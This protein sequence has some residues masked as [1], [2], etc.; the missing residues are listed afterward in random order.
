MKKLLNK[1]QTLSFANKLIDLGIDAVEALRFVEAVDRFG[2]VLNE[3]L[4]KNTHHAK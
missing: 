3:A 2:V 4:K 1:K